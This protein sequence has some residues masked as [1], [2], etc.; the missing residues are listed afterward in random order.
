MDPKMVSYLCWMVK[1]LAWDTF[2]FVLLFGTVLGVLWL[3]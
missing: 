3:I 1:D 2:L